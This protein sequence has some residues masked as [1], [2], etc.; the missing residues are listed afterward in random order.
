MGQKE[1][2]YRIAMSMLM[3]CALMWELCTKCKAKG[4]FLLKDVLEMHGKIIEGHKRAR[5]A[6]T[7]VKYCRYPDVLYKKLK[8]VPGMYAYDLRDHTMNLFINTIDTDPKQGF[9][10]S[11]LLDDVFVM[12]YQFCRWNGYSSLLK[13]AVFC[14]DADGMY[15]RLPEWKIPK[16]RVPARKPVAAKQPAKVEVTRIKIDPQAVLEAARE[17]AKQRKIA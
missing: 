3:Q 1:I 16:E 4:E 2:N 10:C 5:V 12:C 6:N 9:H 14:N 11:Y 13:K 7:E 15:A 8:L 17:L